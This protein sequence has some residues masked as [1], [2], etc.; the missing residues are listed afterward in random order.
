[1]TPAPGFRC[2]NGRC[3]ENDAA[4]L[5]RALHITREE[6][7]PAVQIRGEDFYAADTPH[8]STE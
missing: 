6:R 3:I 4:G 2:A 8:V 1:M 7:P 5:D